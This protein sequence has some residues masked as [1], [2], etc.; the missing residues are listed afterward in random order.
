MTKL[1]IDGTEMDVAEAWRTVRRELKAYGAGLARKPEIIALNKCDALM[2]EA[3]AEK[4]LALAKA[5]FGSR[6]KAKLAE[7]AVISGV[8]GTGLKDMVRRLRVLAR[9]KRKGG[10]SRGRSTKAKSP[11]EK[12]ARAA[13]VGAT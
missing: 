13:G 5:R 3:I 10:A 9:M 8:A 12:S 4:R 2:P 11:R 6:A 1:L 7:I